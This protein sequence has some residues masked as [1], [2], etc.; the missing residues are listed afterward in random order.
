[1]IAWASQ[2]R[3]LKKFLR[4]RGKSS[5]DADDLVQEAFLRLHVFME[6]GHRVQR[7][8][9][10]LA[11]TALNLVVDQRRRD[12]SQCR[13]RFEPE[14]IEDLPL[15]DLGPTPEEILLAERRLMQIRDVLDRKVSVQTR[16]VFFL[17][18]LEGF[19]YDEIAARMNITVRMV[20]RHIARAITVMWME[21]NPE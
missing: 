5:E 18:R 16:E 3:R 8:E 7:P 4:R 20:E 10:F 19:T 21:G 14:S 17:H 6:G 15:M 9:A 11:R 13:D 2:L 1:M 12:R